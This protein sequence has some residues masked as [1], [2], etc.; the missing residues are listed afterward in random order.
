MSDH[1]SS[2]SNQQKLIAALRDPHCYAQ[3]VPSMQVIETHIS[4]VLLAGDYAYKIKKAIN[5]GFLDYSELNARRHFCDEEVRLNRRT[6]PDIYLD[7]VPIGGSPE[8]PEFGAKPALEYAVKMRR[9][10]FASLMDDLLLRGKISA[11]HVDRLAAR[12]ARFHAGVSVADAGSEFGTAESIH[13]AALQNFG[14]LRALLTDDAD[15]ENVAALEVSTEAEYAECRKNFETRRMQGF[16]RECHGDLHL[17]NIVLMGDEPVPF[18]CIEFNPALRWIDVMDEVAFAVMDLLH[19]DHSELAWRL[20][21]AYLEAGGDYG[22]VSVLRFYLAYRATVRAKVCAIRVAQT[23]NSGRAKSDEMAAC[24]SY[25]AL[26]RQCLGQY[27]PA[28]II[29]HGLP[30][31]GKTTF[32]QLA[33]QQMGGI[34]IRSDVERKRLFGLGTLENSRAAVGDIYSPEATRRTYAHLQELARE[35]MLAGFPVIV[36]AAF[37]K[38]DEREAF[39]ELA[40]SMSV[41]F[42]IASLHAEDSRLRD[43]IR[44]RRND[45]SEADVA[46]LDMLQSKQQPLSPRELLCTAIF[47]T[48]EPPDSAANTRAWNQLERMRVSA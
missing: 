48:E 10:D 16:V 34:R 25:L 5:L 27:R 36:D 2:Y 32:S 44:Q 40:Q 19:R 31:S 28:L 39:R 1:H 42:A 35:I 13:A 15:R 4:W 41:P 21:N 7:T 14:Q 8:A 45:A 29:T 20:L 38:Q 3:N 12:I 33:L 22:G 30:G 23:H 17:G 47:T 6:A 43:R 37:L 46:V 11:L 26:A 9:F 24:R 18:D